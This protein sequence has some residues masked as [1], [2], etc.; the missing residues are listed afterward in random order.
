MQEAADRK[1]VSLLET[2][3][4]AEHEKSRLEQRERENQIRVA[5]GLEPLPAVPEEDEDAL[6]EDAGLA[7]DEDEDKFDVVL[8]E[9]SKVLG[10]YIELSGAPASRL[11]AG[12]SPPAA[13]PLNDP[14]AAASAPAALP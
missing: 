5:H 12:D 10:D 7:D 4:R 13:A 11:A 2:K 6:D 3:R 9:A 8:E 1:Q 14:A